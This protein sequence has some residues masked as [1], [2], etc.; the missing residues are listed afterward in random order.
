MKSPMSAK[1]VISSKRSRISSSDKPRML[2][3][4]KMF[5]TPVKEGS[6]PE[7]NSSRAATRPFTPTAPLVGVIVPAINCSRVDLPAPF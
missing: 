5:S 7:P 4:R 3:L 6:K 2:P 1:A